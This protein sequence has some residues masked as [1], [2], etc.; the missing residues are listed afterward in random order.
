MTRPS[1]RASGVNLVANPNPFDSDL[2][3]EF[4]GSSLLAQNSVFGPPYYVSG[5]G[6]SI[7]TPRSLNTIQFTNV[8][9][10]YAQGWSLDSNTGQ[11]NL[12]W[13]NSD[14]STIQPTLIYDCEMNALNLTGNPDGLY[15]HGFQLPCYIYL[16]Q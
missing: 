6:Q 2:V 5:S 4:T 3:V 1:A 14:G 9:A 10:Q 11:L 12:T 8:D 15:A 7:L 16:T 13:T